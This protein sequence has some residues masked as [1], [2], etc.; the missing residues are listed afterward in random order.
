MAH[1]DYYTAMDIGSAFRSKNDVG[2]FLEAMIRDDAELYIEN[3]GVNDFIPPIVYNDAGKV[4]NVDY[5]FLVNSLSK[6]LDDPV[7]NDDFI[8]TENAK[9]EVLK[10]A[11][12]LIV[13]IFENYY[14][15]VRVRQKKVDT[16]KF[17]S[18]KPFEIKDKFYNLIV[19]RNKENLKRFSAVPF[20]AS[21]LKGML[22]EKDYA[23]LVSMSNRDTLE[24]VVF[25]AVKYQEFVRVRGSE[26][27]YVTPNSII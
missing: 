24:Q 14:D 27:E 18:N 9:A 7:V 13:G 25:G 3:E 26:V 19:I 15:V 16:S 22:H 4:F 10:N 6:W 23:L 11:M 8:L 1:F 20:S 2:E 5:N 12:H 21:T 17:K